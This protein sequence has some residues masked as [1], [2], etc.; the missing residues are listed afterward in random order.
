MPEIQIR[1]DVI[2][3][4]KEYVA[5]YKNVSRPTQ[6]AP[7]MLLMGKSNWRV[8]SS[9]AYTD[10]IFW[11]VTTDPIDWYGEWRFRDK[12]DDFT[13]VL[14]R[15]ICQGT[16][17]KKTKMGDVTIKIKP[18]MVTEFKWNNPIVGALWYMWFRLFYQHE[19]RKT[20][21]LE[22]VRVQEFDDEVR[23]M[24]GIGRREIHGPTTREL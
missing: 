11:D 1:T 16:Y 6:L 15:V 22:Q 23:T 4:E 24:L 9:C 2:A 13:K 21:R 8:P 17:D 20:I 18:V 5:T 10:K 3:P 19:L 12:R 7:E 14:I